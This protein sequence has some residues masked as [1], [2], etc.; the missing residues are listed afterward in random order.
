MHRS[1]LASPEFV[2][3]MNENIVLI[4]SHSDTGH[5]EGIEDDKGDLQPG[6]P[7]YPGLTC[8]QHRAIEEEIR[9]A[10]DPLPKIDF[11]NGRP[12]AFLVAPGG[13]VTRMDSATQQTPD[14]IQEL[15][16]S[17]QKTAG[18][19]IPWKKF[20]EYQEDF[21][22]CE[23]AAAAGKFK[24]AIKSVQRVEK[25]AGKLPEAFQAEVAARMQALNASIQEA[26]QQ[27]TTSEADPAAKLKQLNEL[28]LQA[29][30]RLSKG[31]LPVVEAIN[32]A[33]KEAKS[34]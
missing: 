3:W 8:E 19:H 21:S 33:I 20:Q 16:E 5:P 23:A 31:Y 10:A 4:I 11:G 30:L 29:S 1:V 24:D 13:E 7:V 6:C 27:I 2:A 28:R 25:E 9:G 12:V 32:A 14:K 22:A 26:L 15:V 17:L 34:K 18:K